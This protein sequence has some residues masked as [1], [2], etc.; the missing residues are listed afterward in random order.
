MAP[1]GAGAG[2]RRVVSVGDFRSHTSHL[3]GA[4]GAACCPGVRP[5][6][7]SWP[8]SRRPRHGAC[9][10]DLRVE[11]AMASAV[12]SASPSFP[13]D[14]PP[15]PEAHAGGRYRA[16]FRKQPGLRV[17]GARKQTA[18]WH[19]GAS[20][21]ELV[22]FVD[23]APVWPASPLCFLCT[24]RCLTLCSPAVVGGA[25]LPPVAMTP[26]LTPEP[27][28]HPPFPRPRGNKGIVRSVDV[29]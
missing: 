17:E 25:Q 18:A 22:S 1:R 8:R 28:A 29:T 21:H 20:R 27:A 4:A 7:L 15:L 2:N 5:Q 23:T 26:P 24:P 16:L 14:P 13:P 10:P 19:A 12:I 6:H 11:P 3:S 9:K